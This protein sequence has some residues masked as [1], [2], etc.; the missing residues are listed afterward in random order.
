[1]GHN[2]FVPLYGWN[3]ESTSEMEQGFLNTEHVVIAIHFWHTEGRLT[4]I[5]HRHYLTSDVALP[6]PRCGAT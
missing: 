3:H 4:S 6:D 5:F 1:M 2:I